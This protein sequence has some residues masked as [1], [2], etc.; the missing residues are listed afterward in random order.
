MKRTGTITLAMRPGWSWLAWWVPVAVLTGLAVAAVAPDIAVLFGYR[1]LG[2][3]ASVGQPLARTLAIGAASVAGSSS[4][5]AREKSSTASSSSV[6]LTTGAAKHALR[7]CIFVLTSLQS[8][9]QHAILS[10]SL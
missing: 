10:A 7:T 9:K 4:D 6:T 2:V 5:S 3:T 8:A 1:S